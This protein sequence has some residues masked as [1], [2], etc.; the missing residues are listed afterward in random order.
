MNRGGFNMAN[1]TKLFIS[2]KTGEEDGLTFCAHTLHQFLSQRPHE[3]EVWLD[4]V[5]LKAGGEWDSQIYEQIPNSDVL[6]LLVA[7]ATAKSTWVAREVDYAKGARVPVLPVLI[8][9]GYDIKSVMERFNL[10]TVQYVSLLNGN[11]D[12]LEK[13]VRSIEDLKLNRAKAQAAWLEKLTS[14]Q[15]REPYV[16]KRRDWQD[17]PP[18]TIEGSGCQVG[19]AA[20]DLFEGAD[21][22][23]YV[24]SE[25]DYMQMARIFESKTISSLLRYYGSKLDGAGRIVEDT[26]QDELNLRIKE[27]DIKT[28]PVEIGTVIVT[29]AGSEASHLRKRKGRFIFHIATVSVVG[30]GPNKSLECNLVE[31]SVRRCVRRVLDTVLEVNKKRGVVSPDKTE[32][33]KLQ[34]AAQ[35]TYQPIRSIVLPL[36][37]AGHGGRPA[38]QIVSPVVQAIKEFLIDMSADDKKAEMTLENIYI[39]AYFKDDVELIHATLIEQFRSMQSERRVPIEQPGT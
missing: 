37:G 12:E 6:I 29:S 18:F 19:I 5:N 17:F 2:Y 3:Y 30:D 24:N 11:K 13:L 34:E 15:P 26:V 10:N 31:A 20:G 7:E 4:V 16:P 14:Q 23:V 9:S 38:N 22:D 35:G 28:R 21:I 33:R 39:T 27:D 8:R 36:F 32:Q 1:A 25:N